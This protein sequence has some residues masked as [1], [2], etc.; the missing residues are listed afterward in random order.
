M[1]LNNRKDKKK[2]KFKRKKIRLLQ[3]ENNVPR[4]LSAYMT[5][6]LCWLPFLKFFFVKKQSEA[7]M[8]LNC[9]I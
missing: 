5:L 8:N 6:N 2:L 1:I 7:T 3:S 9:I 4:P